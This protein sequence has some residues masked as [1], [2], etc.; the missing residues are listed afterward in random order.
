MTDACKGVTSTDIKTFP[1]L[2][3]MPAGK[4]LCEFVARMVVLLLLL[5]V[6]MVATRRENVGGRGCESNC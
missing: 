1:R 2:C 4:S 5:T 6:V 3:E